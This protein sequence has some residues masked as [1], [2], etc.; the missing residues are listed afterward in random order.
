ML[1]A[2]NIL[3][4]VQVTVGRLIF[5]FQIYL[6]TNFY[7]YIC[8]LSPPPASVLARVCVYVSACRS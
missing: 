4:R 8:M 3:S 2:V 5:C 1:K 7:I 6:K